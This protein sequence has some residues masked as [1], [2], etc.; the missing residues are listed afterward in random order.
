MAFVVVGF[1]VYAPG[2]RKRDGTL[3]REKQISK[4][5]AVRAAAELFC[6]IARKGD[7]PEAFV[8]EVMKHDDIN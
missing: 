1:M 3:G 8:R 4:Q 7:Y 5:Y 2:P 6:E